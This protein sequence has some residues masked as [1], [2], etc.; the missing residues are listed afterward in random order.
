M[1]KPTILFI[2]SRSHSHPTC[3]EKLNGVRR[4]AV[5][6]DWNLVTR[7]STSNPRQIKT[8]LSEIHPQGCIVSASLLQNDL[9]PKLFCGLPLVY[10]DTDPNLFP[11][12]TPVIYHDCHK[13]GV[14]AAQE[15]MA[16]KVTRFIYLPYWLKRFWDDARWEGYSD[17]LAQHGHKAI[18]LASAS[19]KDI[20]TLKTG[21]G[22]LTSNDEMAERIL[23]LLKRSNLHIPQDITLISADDT[24]FSRANGITSIRIDFEQ[25]GYYAAET[26]AKL[27]ERQPCESRRTFGDVCIQYRESTRHFARKLPRIHEAI[28]LIRAQACNGLRA[29]SV[30]QFIGTPRRT[31]EE[32]FRLATGHSIHQE[33]Q[34]VRLERVFA[35]L[36]SPGRSISSLTD[37][38]GYST[39]Q[40]LRK[41]FRC[42]TGISM[43]E[44]RKRTFCDRRT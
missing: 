19:L 8:F 12:D 36:S 31:A 4:F 24:E 2:D 23:P 28:E 35:L 17:C 37:L 25:G 16:H 29:A 38:C 15:L 40:A 20:A 6:R 27:M 5:T 39:P 7:I 9:S 11:Q 21:D 30:V 43:N 22:I 26:L 34:A 32:H 44:W 3:Q 13:T 14:R 18:R 42:H 33:I 1:T 41:A 10:I